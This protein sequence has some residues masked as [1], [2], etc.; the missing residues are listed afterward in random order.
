MKVKEDFL[1]RKVAGCYVVVP[2]GRATVDFNGM[3]NLNETGA[4]LWE[5]LQN[6]TTKEE[7]VASLLKEYEIAEDIASRDVDVYIKKLEDAGLIE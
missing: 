2:V 1:L 6:D 3:L 5:K 7:L 4:F